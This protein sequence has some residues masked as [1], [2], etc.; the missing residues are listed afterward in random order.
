VIVT[1]L[2][3][4]PFVRLGVEGMIIIR[5]ALNRNDSEWF[6]VPQDG[7]SDAPQN[8]NR[9]WNSPENRLLLTGDGESR[10]KERRYC[11]VPRICL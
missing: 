1:F 7:V 4:G 11:L 2:A 8:D 3:N 6:G 9:T 5:K 10:D